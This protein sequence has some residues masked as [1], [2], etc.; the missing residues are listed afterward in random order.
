[1]FSLETMAVSTHGGSLS[2][3]LVTSSS[4][5]KLM[6]K[7]LDESFDKL[8]DDIKESLAKQKIFVKKVADVL[9]SLLP[10]C[11]ENHYFFLKE[12]VKCLF[13][14]A[15]NDELF[16]HMNLHW[17][18]LDPSLLDHLITKLDLKEV[19]VQIEKYKSNLQ[20][21]RMKTPLNL[22]C[23]AQ[24]RK[25]LQLSPDFYEVAARFEWP[26]EEEVTL[27]HVE[28]FRQEYA[29]HYNLHQFAMMLFDVRPGSILVVWMVP[30]SITNILRH[31]VPLEILKK[32]YVTELTIA[33]TTIY[34]C[35]PEKEVH[36][37]KLQIM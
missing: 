15:D 34:Q 6:I 14:S 18:Y 16:G 10:D 21:F 22:F 25:R 20:E 5:V 28:Q 19:Q 9:T 26:E 30:K 2:V 8:K 11:D 24:R 12:N 27:E 29:S 17:N 36:N 31:N 7:K 37:I 1:M 23:L 33:G 13:G 3:V 32:Y 4:E 35:S